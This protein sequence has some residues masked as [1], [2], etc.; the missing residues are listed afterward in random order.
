MSFPDYAKTVKAALVTNGFTAVLEVD[1]DY[2]P[3]VGAPLVLV[4]DDG[5]PAVVDGAWLVG[6]SPRRTL[7]RLTAFAA[8]RTEAFTTV[9]DAAEWVFTNR[10]GI[11][12]VEDIST[13]LM[14]R[15]R[16]TGAALGSITMPVI[17]RTT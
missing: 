6:Q 5:G 2:K 16:A 15:D 4:A 14:T 11:A 12:R 9:T 17:V 10:P 3:T 1:E 8:G 7:L 13:A